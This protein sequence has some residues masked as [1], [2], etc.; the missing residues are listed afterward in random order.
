MSSSTAKEGNF[1]HNPIDFTIYTLHVYTSA[2]VRL[3]SPGGAWDL[4]LLSMWETQFV[5]VGILCYYRHTSLWQ[6]F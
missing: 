6:Q 2:P 1:K 3:T 4:H 5:T